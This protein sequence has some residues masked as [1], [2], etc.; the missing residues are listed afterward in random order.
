MNLE[1]C[2]DLIL[3]QEDGSGEFFFFP[4]IL[5]SVYDGS[6]ILIGEEKWQ[7]L[8]KWYDTFHILSHIIYLIDELGVEFLIP[9][10]VFCILR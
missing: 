5:L 2:Y 10:L 3:F 1:I 6:E 7:E 9:R 8:R 4:A